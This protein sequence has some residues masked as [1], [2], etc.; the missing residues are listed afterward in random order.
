MAAQL[1]T[2]RVMDYTT[3]DRIGKVE[4]DA[5]EMARYEAC[6]HDAYQWPEGIAKAGDV[7]SDED[8]ARLDIPAGKVIYL[9]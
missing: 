8:L 6:E 1:T 7:L 2:A 9:D 5:A 3:G 4:I